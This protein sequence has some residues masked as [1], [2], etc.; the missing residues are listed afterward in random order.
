MV[1]LIFSKLTG[2]VEK[3]QKIQ[4]ESKLCTS[5]IPNDLKEGP[6]QLMCRCC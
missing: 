4:H 5:G 3:Q 6:V 1:A 2:T